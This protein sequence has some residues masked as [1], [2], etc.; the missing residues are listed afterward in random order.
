MSMIVSFCHEFVSI[1][2]PKTGGTSF[3][4]SLEERLGIPLYCPDDKSY[5]TDKFH[6]ENA[7]FSG[8]PGYLTLEEKFG[9]KYDDYF[10]FAFVRNP[11]SRMASLTFSR[12]NRDRPDIEVTKAVFQNKLRNLLV[13]EN[14]GIRFNLATKPQTHWLFNKDGELKVD[15]V[16]RF[17]NYAEECKYLMR[18]LNLTFNIKDVNKSYSSHVDYRDYYNDEL[19]EMVAKKH[20][21]DIELFGYIY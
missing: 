5:T 6:F 21:S 15:H 11:W 20:K 12:F 17:E 16:A 7:D 9:N 19:I 1:H 2:V 10:K 13:R 3:R 14:E 4:T 8:H 18:R